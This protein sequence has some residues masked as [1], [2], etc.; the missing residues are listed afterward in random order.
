MATYNGSRFV[1]A[2]IES[3][4]AQIEPQDEL[5]VY[6]DASSDDTV[7]VV[8]E[9]SAGRARIIVGKANVGVNQ[10]F[11]HVIAAARGDVIVMADQD[12]LWTPG[13]LAALSAPFADARTNVVASNH[14]LIDEDD[15]ALP[16]S[17][18]PDLVAAYDRRPLANLAGIMRGT[19]NY[20]GCA[21]ALRAS[22]RDIVLP[23]PDDTESHDIWIAIAAIVDGS[24]VHIPLVTLLHRVHGNNA[25]ILRRSLRAKLR[26]RQLLAKQIIIAKR[27]LHLATGPARMGHGVTRDGELS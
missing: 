18:A 9:A 13:R 2:Q 26:A 24:L 6:D 16:G 21:M 22:F 27:R 10:A 4:L 12:D 23:L 15:L 11:A 14:R 3:I 5:V 7:A 20:Y 17:L 1:R 19:R 25:S 8:E